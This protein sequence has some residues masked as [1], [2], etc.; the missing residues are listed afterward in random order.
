M[1]RKLLLTTLVAYLF[2]FF[3]FAT[4]TKPPEA[5]LSHKF[6]ENIGQINDEYAP[7][8]IK[9]YIQRGLMNVYFLED[10]VSYVLRNP[11]DKDGVASR[12]DLTFGETTKPQIYGLEGKESK[13][14]IYTINCAQGANVSEYKK[15]V[16]ENIYNN[17]DLVYYLDES[18]SLKYDFIVHPGGDP[19]EI[20]IS[21]K[22]NVELELLEDGRVEL[23]SEAGKVYEAAPYTYLEENQ[24]E[25]STA[26]SLKKEKL[27]FD[28]AKYDE[29]L[30][31]VIDPEIEWSTY[32]GGESF[33]DGINTAIDAS[34][35]LYLTGKTYS[36]EFPNISKD[37]GNGEKGD[38]VIGK[39]LADGTH[40]WTIYYGGD[41]ESE[42]RSIATDE[43]GNVFVTGMTKSLFL[44]NPEDPDNPL[45]AS[46]NEDVVVVKVGLDSS[47]VRVR[48]YGS[49]NGE[50]VGEGIEYDNNGLYITGTTSTSETEFPVTPGAHQVI[51]A[52]D[53][54]GFLIRIDTDMNIIWSTYIGGS[55]GDESN[56]VAVDSNGDPYIVGATNSP[57]LPLATNPFSPG[58]DAEATDAFVA[59]F[60]KTNGTL[61][62]LEYYGGTESDIGEDIVAFESDLIY[63]VG[64]TSSMNLEIQ[65]EDTTRTFQD[66]YGGGITDAF[67]FQLHA[68][69]GLARWS[70][71]LGGTED[72]YA[73][74]VTTTGGAEAIVTGYTESEDFPTVNNDNAIRGNFQGG[75][76]DAFLTLFSDAGDVRTSGFIGGSNIDVGRDV[77]FFRGETEND[78]NLYVIGR[79]RSTDFPTVGNS[80]QENYNGGADIFIYTIGVVIDSAEVIDTTLIGGGSGGAGDGEGVVPTDTIPADFCDAVR[81]NVISLNPLYNQIFGNAC[82]EDIPDDEVLFF[83]SVPEIIGEA[84]AFNYLY[85][86]SPDGEVYQNVRNEVGNLAM[87][88]N[89]T[90]GQTDLQ[91]YFALAD[92]L[93]VRRLVIAEG[94]VDGSG[95]ELIFKTDFQFAFPDFTFEANCVGEPIQ[96]SD[97]SNITGAEITSYEYTVTAGAEQETF[98]TANPVIGP[99]FTDEITVTLEIQSDEGCIGTETKTI[100]LAGEVQA[101]IATEPA[102]GCAGFEQTFT[103]TSTSDSPIVSF[104]WDFGGGITSNE[105]NP[106]IL[107]TEV[108]T[109]RTISLTV[110]TE[111]GCTSTATTQIDIFEGPVVDANAG[112]DEVEVVACGDT[113]ELNGSSSV[114]TV[115]WSQVS[116]PG[117]ATFE[118]PSV[119]NATVTVD[120]FGTYV[121]EITANNNGCIDSDRIT[122]TFIE[123][124][125]ASFELTSNEQDILC[126]GS[127]VVFSSTSTS[128]GDIVNYEWDLG[129]GETFSGPEMDEVSTEY[130]T[131]G[132]KT[133]T[134]TIT[135]SNGCTSTASQT[136]DADAGEVVEAPTVDAGADREIMEGETISLDPTVNIPSGQELANSLWTSNPTGAFDPDPN[137]PNRIDPSRLRT[138]AM[139]DEDSH[140]TL[141]V[142]TDFGCTAEDS[143]FVSVGE[144]SAE[145]IPDIF[146]PNNDGFNDVFQIPFLKNFPNAKVEIF[147]RW[148]SLVYSTRQYFNNPWDGTYNGEPAPAGVYYY[149]ISIPGRNEIEGSVTLVR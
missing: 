64:T 29:D 68:A 51:K 109:N 110:T 98:N 112:S 97:D 19:S 132:D 48:T 104:N 85:Q 133:I 56:D 61:I 118:D 80:H 70:S 42:G 58:P 89:L 43:S 146:T 108:A 114:G 7:T 123:A 142:E 14:K 60:N 119:A 84:Q 32:Y 44:P 95:D 92:T 71:Y 2:I 21:Y 79:T 131:P 122:V 36:L 113:F 10:R 135:T 100:S 74:G 141:M 96:L 149:V 107:F 34:G 143:L 77:A 124:P 86:I 125:N 147:N 40:A 144:P 93:F 99:Y 127:T 101:G 63:I 9:F 4:E 90:L 11:D 69:N 128:Q 76:E 18:G 121:F 78:N 5:K 140:L 35:N 67:I 12:I 45:E 25:I 75:E 120:V 117:T 65:N 94:C 145:G 116:G 59:K 139:P 38:I 28:I 57:D 81:N 50:D 49:F 22:G 91:R 16:Y 106:T 115:E 72:D 6:I 3:A 23:T 8:D 47:P 30:T 137:N 41:A 130:T 20:E 148:G 87:S 55:G 126:L 66:T 17:I 62:W 88:K 15:V 46:G 82:I 33:D 37:F 39:F 129:N 105:E 24:A 26:Y 27:T 134:L 138:G 13:I 103:S 83:G 52:A 1:K 111:N 102:Q 31:L 73:K 53:L 136:F 54:D